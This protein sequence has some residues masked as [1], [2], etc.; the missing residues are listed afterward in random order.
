M[1]LQ[2]YYVYCLEVFQL[3]RNGHIF[4]AMPLLFRVEIGKK[5]LYAL[6]DE[7]KDQ[8]IKRAEAEG[9]KYP[10]DSIRVRRNESQAARETTMH[11]DKEGS[12]S[13]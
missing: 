7:E 4:I 8:I 11:P 10:S 9:A 12:C 2:H 5:V 3:V 1:V 13:C 6:D